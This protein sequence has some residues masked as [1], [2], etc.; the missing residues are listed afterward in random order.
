MYLATIA[1]SSQSNPRF[2]RKARRDISAPVREHIT[3]NLIVEGA[4]E[5]VESDR[6]AYELSFLDDMSHFCSAFAF[7]YVLHSAYLFPQR[8]GFGRQPHNY[9]LLA[10]RLWLSAAQ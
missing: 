1:A 7:H 10:M 8:V 2:N 5:Q 4:D 6:L 3:D 9:D